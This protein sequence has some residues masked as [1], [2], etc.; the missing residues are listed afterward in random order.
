MT[1]NILSNRVSYNRIGMSKE[2]TRITKA[3]VDV[4]I[5]IHVE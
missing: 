2:S 5:I 4:L 3:E 1:L